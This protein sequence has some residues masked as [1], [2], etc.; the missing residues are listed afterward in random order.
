MYSQDCRQHQGPG[1][2]QAV[3]Q[4]RSPRAQL[5][6][7]LPR[8]GQCSRYRQTQYCQNLPATG[9]RLL[10]THLARTPRQPGL[11]FE[12]EPRTYP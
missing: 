11:L 2:G 12:E 1:S 8:R 3:R 6:H 9:L 7:L 10:C 5:V 4:N